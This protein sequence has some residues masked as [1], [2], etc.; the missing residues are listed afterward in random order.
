VHHGETYD[1]NY[2]NYLT[3]GMNDVYEETGSENA[4]EDSAYISDEDD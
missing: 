4:P 2:N 3:G 1:E